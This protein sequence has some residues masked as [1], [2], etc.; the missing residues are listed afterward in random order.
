MNASQ[1]AFSV[2]PPDDLST[3]ERTR[4]DDHSAAE[5]Q[6]EEIIHGWVVPDVEVFDPDQP[7]LCSDQ[8]PLPADELPIAV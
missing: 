4:R 3:C 2:C 6:R 1:P 5:P 7:P 8:P